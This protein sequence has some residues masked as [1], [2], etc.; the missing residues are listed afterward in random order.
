MHQA[1]SQNAVPIT[2]IPQFQPV[3]GNSIMNNRPGQVN[4]PPSNMTNITSGM[5]SNTNFMGQL[6]VNKAI[7]PSFM[8]PMAP[9]MT[10]MTNPSFITSSIPSQT[11]QANQE[12]GNAQ[13]SNSTPVELAADNQ[14]LQTNEVDGKCEEGENDGNMQE[15]RVEEKTNQETM[16]ID[17]DS[18]GAVKKDDP[19]VV[20]VKQENEQNSPQSNF[21]Q[22]DL[23]K[24]KER[25][26]G[27]DEESGN[28]NVFINPEVRVAIMIITS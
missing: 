21:Y 18:G 25:K 27:L 11:N 9:N 20:E 22:L 17:G 14:S 16:D 4:V 23:N 7:N 8:N 5:M 19:E 26:K 24:L 13:P 28:E 12:T 2:S 15:E 6:P 10:G 3:M 1:Y